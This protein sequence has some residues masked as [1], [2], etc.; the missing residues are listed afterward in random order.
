LYKTCYATPICTS[1]RVMI[2]TG[3]YGFRTGYFNFKGRLYAPRADSPRSDI[4][5]KVTFADVLKQAGYATG[6]AGKWQLTGKV[7]TMI[8]DCG[9][10]EYRMWAYHDDLPAGVEHTG[11]FEN[12]RT[13][14]T[15]RYWHP[16]IMQ[17]GQYMPS[18]PDDYGPNLFT[19]FVI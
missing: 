2:M 17:N 11:A 12:P 9:F 3:R 15:S 4:G 16:C 5:A 6:L 7:P 8:H 1:S 10:D 13:K 19:D 14:K 18:Q